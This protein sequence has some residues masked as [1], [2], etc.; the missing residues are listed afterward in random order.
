MIT[1][2][3][4]HEGKDYD[5]RVVDGELVVSESGSWYNIPLTDKPKLKEM[6]ANAVGGG[7]VDMAVNAGK[8]RMRKQVIRR[9]MDKWQENKS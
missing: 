6:A 5:V 7:G 3:I 2:T 8:R 4:T 1:K 9:W